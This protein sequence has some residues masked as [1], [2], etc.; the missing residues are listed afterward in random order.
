MYDYGT[1]SSSAPVTTANAGMVAPDRQSIVKEYEWA[2]T[3]ID[4]AL[5]ELFSRLEPVLDPSY[6][7]GCADGV[8]TPPVS[9]ARS[10]LHHLQGLAASVRGITARLEV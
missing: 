2:I 8:P 1:A 6:P 10:R 3:D 5:K 4:A 9:E 7:D